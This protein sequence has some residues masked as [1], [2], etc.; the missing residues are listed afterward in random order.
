MRHSE[1]ERSRQ[2]IAL[3]GGFVAR[4][5]EPFGMGV[6]FKRHINHRCH[7]SL[8]ILLISNDFQKGDRVSTGRKPRAASCVSRKVIVTV[9]Q[10]WTCVGRWILDRNDSAARSRQLDP[11]RSE[12]HLRSARSRAL[13]INV[14]EHPDA[15]GD[16]AQCQHQILPAHRDLDV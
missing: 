12:D 9:D 8:L 11:P 1:S 5:I 7:D 10:D 6:M 2:G 3:H 16:L 15:A 14:I 13:V 4:N